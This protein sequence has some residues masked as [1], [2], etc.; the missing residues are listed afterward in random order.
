MIDECHFAVERA[1]ARASWGK[2]EDNGEVLG[3]N[4]IVRWLIRGVSMGDRYLGVVLDAPVVY[5]VTVF[6]DPQTC[7]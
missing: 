2:V 6:T 3:A 7:R 4:G 5:G 1:L